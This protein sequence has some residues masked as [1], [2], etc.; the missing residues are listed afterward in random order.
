MLP[1]SEKARADWE[2]ARDGLLVQI[3]LFLWGLGLWF[4]K[5]VPHEHWYVTSLWCRRCGRSAQDIFRKERRL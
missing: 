5:V 1:S 4:W 2:A 3:D